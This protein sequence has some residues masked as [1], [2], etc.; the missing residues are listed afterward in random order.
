MGQ[1]EL[2]AAYSVFLCLILKT[3]LPWKPD[4]DERRRGTSI[5]VNEQKQHLRDFYTVDEMAVLIVLGLVDAG[6]RGPVN[7]VGFT[8][9]GR[10]QPHAHNSWKSTS[11]SGA[12]HLTGLLKVQHIPVG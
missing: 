7:H 10:P 4:T 9:E 2:N 5:D 8:N 1:S 3:R 6:P 11:H 12:L